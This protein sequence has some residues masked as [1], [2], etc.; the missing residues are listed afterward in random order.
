MRGSSRPSRA[1]GPVRRGPDVESGA[2]ASLRHVLGASVGLVLGYP[3]AIRTRNATVQTSVPRSETDFPR[4]KTRTTNQRQTNLSV[5]DRQTLQKGGALTQFQLYSDVTADTAHNEGLTTVY[6]TTR[7][8]DAPNGRA[9]LLGRRR[10]DTRHSRSET[11][12]PPTRDRRDA[13]QAERDGRAGNAES[14][15]ERSGRGG[16]TS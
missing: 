10:F 7:L 15:P 8:A 13:A 3:F 6:Q 11:N 5:S 9:C 14:L 4:S 12:L 16:A 2:W 1:C